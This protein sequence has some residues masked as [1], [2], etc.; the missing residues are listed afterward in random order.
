MKQSI[1]LG[2]NALLSAEID[3]LWFGLEAK[4][5]GRK[6]LFGSTRLC[7][8]LQKRAKKASRIELELKMMK[9]EIKVGDCLAGKY[10]L[11][12]L[13]VN[14]WNEIHFED[15]EYLKITWITRSRDEKFKFHCSRGGEISA[16]AAEEA[17]GK[18]N[19]EICGKLWKFLEFLLTLVSY[20]A[21]N[22]EKN[23]NQIKSNLWNCR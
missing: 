10:D 9:F 2:S 19:G 7:V 8:Y 16:N 17:N 18:K 21:I 12:K 4:V 3:F 15:V 11:S 1:N 22:E 23:K 14:N 5:L 6:G 13:I 20:C